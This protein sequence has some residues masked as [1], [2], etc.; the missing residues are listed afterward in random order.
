MIQP[1]GGDSGSEKRSDLLA[2]LMGEFLFASLG[3]LEENAF[4]LVDANSCGSVVE[5]AASHFSNVE[6]STRIS[7]FTY[8]CEFQD[9]V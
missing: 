3:H 6:L 4:S 2:G 9:G 8:G 1:L 7:H 5:F